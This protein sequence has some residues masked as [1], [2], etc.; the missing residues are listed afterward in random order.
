MLV[1]EAVEDD[2]PATARI[3]A[4]E[5]EGTEE[6]WLARFAEVLADPSRLFLVAEV[7]G[8]VVGFGQARQV[9]RSGPSKAD[10]PPNGWYLSGV[11]VAGEHR[12]IGVALA[13]T[14]A[15]LERLG[16]VPVHYAAEPENIATISLHERLGFRRAGDITLPGGDRPLLLFRRDPTDRR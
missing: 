7:G 3:I 4:A 6:E 2:L 12:R 9:Q 1:R 10:S 11:T 8:R 15:R 5:A 14:Q 16:D 13:L